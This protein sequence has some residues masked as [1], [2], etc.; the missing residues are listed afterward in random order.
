M[1]RGIT[2]NLFALNPENMKDALGRLF[3]IYAPAL[4]RRGQHLYLL[5]D[6]LILLRKLTSFAFAYLP[7]SLGYPSGYDL[8]EVTDESNQ[9][10]RVDQK[11]QTRC[12]LVV[13]W[14]L[15]WNEAVSIDN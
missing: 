3:F 11:L 9:R 4:L 13:A 12:S 15:F 1:G 6:L 5:I 10:H 14:L 2:S 7:C 8:F